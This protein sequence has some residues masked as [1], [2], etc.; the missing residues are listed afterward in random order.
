M[1]LAAESAPGFKDHPGY[2]VACEPAAERVRVVFNGETVADSRAAL[3]V[4]ETK[5]KPVLYLE[6]YP[7]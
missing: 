4:L 5:H 6:V 1:S 3:R 7:R 2:E